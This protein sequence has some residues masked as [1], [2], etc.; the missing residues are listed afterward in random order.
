MQFIQCDELVE[1]SIADEIEQLMMSRGFPWY[2]YPN[3]NNSIK[4]EDRRSHPTVIC[5]ES[6]YEESFGFSHLI[7]SADNT[8]SPWLRH[9]KQLF[10]LFLNKHRLLPN[11]LLRIKA[12]LLVRS[13]STTGARPF[14]PHVDLPI[15]HWVMIYYVND[16]DGDTVILDKTYPDRENAA[17]LRTVSPKKGRAILFDGRHYHCGTCPVQ[18]DTRIVFNYDFL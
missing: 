17:V 7:F 13:A 1:S 6:R 11:K 10:E 5:D 12:N 4:P 8:N 16:S 15:P 18:H 14:A 9:P 3:V 2:F